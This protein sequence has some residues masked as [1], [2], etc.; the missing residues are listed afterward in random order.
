MSA[1]RQGP[2]QVGFVEGHNVAVEYRWAEGNTGYI[3]RACYATGRNQAQAAYRVNGVSM[4]VGPRYAPIGYE[5]AELNFVAVDLPTNQR[6]GVRHALSKVDWSH[7]NHCGFDDG[8]RRSD[9]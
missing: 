1:L 5:D 6:G 7:H 3:R 9:G 8:Q 2:N 4:Q